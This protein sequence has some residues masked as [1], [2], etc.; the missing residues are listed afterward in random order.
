MNPPKLAGIAPQIVVS[1]AV[2]TARYYQEVLGFKLIGFFPDESECAYV[3][4]ERDGY[5]LHF[6]GANGDLHH[7]D[8]LRKGM[9]DF[10][11]WVP[12]IDA[13]YQE[14]SAKGAK[15]RQEIIRRPYGRE[16]IIED[17]DGHWLQVCD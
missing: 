6:G 9:P 17:C 12:E 13:F 10:I 5:Q 3:M 1:D 4:L 16:F 11:I 7:N 14:V 8:Q 15:I 2:R